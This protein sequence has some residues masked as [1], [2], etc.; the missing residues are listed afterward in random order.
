MAPIEGRA[1]QE[2]LDPEVDQARDRGRGV[3]GVQGGED[4][5]AGE[6]GLDRV[7][8]R[9]GVADLADHDDVRVLAQDV[10]QGAGEV[11]ADLRLHRGLVELLEHH[12]DRILDGGDVELA[13]GDRLERR[14]ERGRLAG[15]GRAGHQD[16]AVRPAD[17]LVE[18]Q[19]LLGVEAE[20]R[21]R[22]WVSTS[23]S[24]MRI[25]IF[26][27]NATGRVETRSSTSL[28]ARVVLMRPSCGRRF[29]AMSRRDMVLMREMTAA[30]TIFG[31]DWMS[32]STPSMR[33][34]IRLELALGLDVDVARARVEG[35]LEHELDGV[36]DVLVARL[37]LGLVLHPDELLEVAEV[38]AGR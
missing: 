21:T 1:D 14:V 34:R 15:A 16:D 28:P 27:P 22:S 5:V 17:E 26:S 8:R 4:E 20:R 35:V 7:L 23:G 24:K 29:S 30:C 31:I 37:D 2:A 32:C 13:G 9:L 10:A 36:D 18:L 38:D 3:V 25:T 33:K 19:H 11:D 12:L 6:R